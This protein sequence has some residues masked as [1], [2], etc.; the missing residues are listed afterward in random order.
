MTARSSTFARPCDTSTQ[1]G[2]QQA[3]GQPIKRRVDPHSRF[4]LPL[5]T[6]TTATAM[7]AIKTDSGSKL[8][9]LH[10]IIKFDALLAAFLPARGFFTRNSLFTSAAHICD[11]LFVFHSHSYIFFFFQ[12]FCH[13]HNSFRLRF[14]ACQQKFLLLPQ[15][16]VRKYV[17]DYIAL[18]WILIKMSAI[19]SGLLP[20]LRE[21][22]AFFLGFR[23]LLFI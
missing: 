8:Q 9:C 2:S 19:L 6:A 13:F 10:I 22:E 7:F 14:F 18:I 3:T 15:R 4:M 23:L 11:F 17:H 12:Y 16:R 21:A 1:K 20:S 5:A